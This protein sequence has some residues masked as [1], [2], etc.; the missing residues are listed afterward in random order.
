MITSIGQRPGYDDTALRDMIEQNANKPGFD[1]STL[2]LPDFGGFA[3]KGDLE[4]RPIYDDTALRD[5]ITSIEKKQNQ[6]EPSPS[7]DDAG[8][9]EMIAKLQEQIS[10][11]TSVAPP[12]ATK[13][14][15]QVSGIEAM[16][17]PGV[18]R[19]S[20]RKVGRG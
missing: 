16:V 20:G 19:G 12:P 3:T 18:L 13:A 11:I 9:R 15:T 14:P 7:Y 2:N 6:R 17:S 1:P 10:G 8:L 4:N 5:M